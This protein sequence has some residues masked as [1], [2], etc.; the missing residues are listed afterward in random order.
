MFNIG[1]YTFAPYKVVWRE[2]W[3]STTAAVIG[4]FDG[5]PIIPDDKLVLAGFSIAEEAH[6]ICAIFNS[7]PAN[8]LL[9]S[10]GI[11]THISQHI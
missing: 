8:L 5:V 2:I 6:Y 10:Y 3:T 9:Q 1:D 4:Q 11:T 7:S